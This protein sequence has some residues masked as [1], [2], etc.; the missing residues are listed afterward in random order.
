M[1]RAGGFIGAFGSRHLGG[2]ERKAFDN[3]PTPAAAT[4]AL[5]DHAPPPPGLLGEPACGDG[6]MARVLEAGGWPVAASDIRRTGYGKAGVD[7]LAAPADPRLVGL[8]TNP[9]FNKAPQFIAKA[10]REAPY[11]AMLLKSTYWHAAKRRAAFER[12]PPQMVLALTWR[13]A[14]LLRE[15]GSAP[16]MDVI[17]SIWDNRLPPGETVYRL[18]EKPAHAPVLEPMLGPALVQLG[19]AADRLLA[20]LEAFNAG[21]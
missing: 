13:P 8:V 4:Q 9:P 21:R 11:V 5:I 15:R 2:A 17:W 20:R 1:I 18:A 16:M 3:Y 12:H 6:A 19:E 10:V 7:Y 14:F